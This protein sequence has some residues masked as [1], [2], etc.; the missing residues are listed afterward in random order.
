MGVIHNIEFAIVLARG[1]NWWLELFF[2]ETGQRQRKMTVLLLLPHCLAKEAFLYEA[3]GAE[4]EP[5][6]I[7]HLREGIHRE[8]PGF[9]GCAVRGKPDQKTWSLLPSVKAI[10]FK[11]LSLSLFF[12]SDRHTL[13]WKEV[14]FF[15]WSLVALSKMALKANKQKKTQ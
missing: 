9:R 13:S 14:C 6:S 12:F 2:L 7:W 3:V 11:T 1:Q 15:N 5:Q 4:G 10:V 8:P